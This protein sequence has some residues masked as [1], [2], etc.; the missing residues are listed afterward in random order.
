[1]QQRLPATLRRYV[2]Y[3]ESA[4]EKAVSTFAAGLDANARILD[5]GAGECQYAH[6]F[7]RQSYV[8]IDLGIGDSEWNYGK[9]NAIGN[10]TALPFASGSFDAAINVVTLE[11]V[12]EPACAL[13]EITRVLA[14]DG[15]LL[16]VVPHE[17]EV[18]QAPHDFFR[19]TRY[20]VRYLLE[21]AGLEAET[22]EPVGGYFRLMSRR[23]LNGLQFFPQPWFYI[24]ALFLVPAG[25]LLPLFDSLDRER[26]CTLGY[27]CIARKRC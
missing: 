10:L 2:L 7:H 15:K 4:I 9:L 1:M 5:A 20:G 8:A 26:N 27:I 21:K 14:H 16:L 22:I 23:L 3:F 25:L 18:H 19:Y 24:A 12:R 11:H 13:I 6:W 17:W